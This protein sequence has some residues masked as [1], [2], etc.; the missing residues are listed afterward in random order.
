M[1]DEMYMARA[2]KLAQRGR[3]PPIRTHASAV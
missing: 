2:L 3:L 1:Q